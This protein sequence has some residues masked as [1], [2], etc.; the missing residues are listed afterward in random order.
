MRR[1]TQQQAIILY[2]ILI[3]TICWTT[4]ITTRAP[5]S[6]AGI[7]NAL[8]AEVNQPVNKWKVCKDLG[9]GPVPGL[10][11]LRQR[12]KLCH[13]QGWEVKA[14]CTDPSRP[15]PT[16]GTMCT[17]QGNMFLCGN[18]SQPMRLYV[19]VATPGP[20]QTPL[21]TITATPTSTLTATPTSS[22]AAAPTS[23]LT[24]TPTS[25]LTA[26]PSST[27]VP[28][29][30]TPAAPQRPPGP[31]PHPGGG[32][33]L[34]MVGFKALVIGV[35][36]LLAGLSVTNRAIQNEPVRREEI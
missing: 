1:F 14:Y 6:A 25:T 28:A 3:V 23:T 8:A 34:Q 36:L 32:S 20:N 10:A 35:L 12:F 4:V 16:V 30:V 17:R 19:I 29:T 31:R 11:G 15:A 13:P 33:N 22:P 18:A 5:A 26:T 21:P 2:V 24:A 27:P 7:E 9:V